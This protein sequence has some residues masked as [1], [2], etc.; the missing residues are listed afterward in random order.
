MKIK[1]SNGSGRK[2]GKSIREYLCTSSKVE[3]KKGSALK[4]IKK[5]LH[6]HVDTKSNLKV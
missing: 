4:T 3:K 5:S 6:H 2:T 1:D